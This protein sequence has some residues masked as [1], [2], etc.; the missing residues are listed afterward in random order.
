V[1]CVFCIAAVAIASATIVPA[2]LNDLEKQL[3]TAAVDLKRVADTEATALWEGTFKFTGA[4]RKS[5][6][7]PCSVTIYKGSKRTRI[8]VKTHS[9]T[10]A[11]NQLLEDRIAK[12]LGAR[13][14][15]RHSAD[16][17]E[18]VGRL[19]DREALTPLEVMERPE[20]EG[21]PGS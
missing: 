9:L 11:D 3:R 5:K 19:G 17:A 15:S 10:A 8:Q 16:H 21:L 2:I 1:V 4:D 20:R 6:T 7:A 13:I 12:L 14:V 18:V